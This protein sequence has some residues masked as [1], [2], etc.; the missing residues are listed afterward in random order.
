M[1]K[2]YRYLYG[3]VSSWRLGSSLGIDPISC[4]DKI[5]TFDCV[6]CQL[7][8]TKVF[9]DRRKIFVPAGKIKKELDLL[10]PLAID[11]ITFSGRGEPTLAENLA[12]MIRTVK[13]VRKEKVAVLTNASLINRR[14]VQRDLSLG[15]FVVAKLDASTA[16]L[17]AKIN[18]P[19][20][21]IKFD[22]VV[23]GLKEFRSQ[24]RGKFALQIMFVGENKAYAASIAQLARLIN[25]DEVQ[26]NTPLRPSSAT[27]L[28]RS[29][30]ETVKDY[31]E[32]LNV[33]SVYAAKKKDV[34][35]VSKESTMRRRGKI[36]S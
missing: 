24:Y 2:D 9:T 17:F 28:S 27:A 20:P 31:F 29:E 14:D 4:E 1:S 32:G 34:R 16:A 8:K 7:G 33:V 36:I 11:Y 10:P 30:M 6:Y 19:M 15:D 18:K 13:A 21:G 26:I 12:E 3:P 35:P 25:P 22:D 5:C 23:E